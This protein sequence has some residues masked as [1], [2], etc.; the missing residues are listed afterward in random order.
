MARWAPRERGGACRSPLAVA[1]VARLWQWRVSLASGCGECRFPLAVA[2]VAHLWLLRVSLASGRAACRSPLAVPRVARLWLWRVSLTSGCC[3]CCSLLAVERVA[4]L[5]LWRVSLASGL[6]TARPTAMC[7]EAAAP[8]PRP[9]PLRRLTRL[10]PP[11]LVCAGCH[12]R[13]AAAAAAH[14]ARHLRCRALMAPQLGLLV[15]L[16]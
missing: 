15:G 1:R 12:R 3:A 6:V 16:F 8:R 13:C 2:H 14:R 9:V 4:R 10:S 11:L 7:A 5:W